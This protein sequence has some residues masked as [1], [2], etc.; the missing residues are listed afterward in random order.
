MKSDFNNHQIEGF[1]NFISNNKEKVLNLLSKP[2][3]KIGFGLSYTVINFMISFP[4][5]I[6]KDII[7]ALYKREDI[8][9]RYNKFH[10]NTNHENKDNDFG[11]DKRFSYYET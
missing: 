1:K 9:K 11:A 5:L 6:D 8:I 2:E 3:T 10:I 7:D 4:E